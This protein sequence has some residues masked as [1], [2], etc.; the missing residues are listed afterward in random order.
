MAPRLPST[1]PYDIGSSEIIYFELRLP[2]RL[3]R[4]DEINPLMIWAG[5]ELNAKRGLKVK[6]NNQDKPIVTKLRSISIVLS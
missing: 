3:G 5:A 2:P 4:L 6:W 1:P